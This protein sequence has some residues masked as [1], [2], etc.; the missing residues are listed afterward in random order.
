MLFP[1]RTAINLIMCALITYNQHHILLYKKVPYLN[2]LKTVPVHQL[3]INK[4][5]INK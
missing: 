1:E 2:T 5:K 3:L 4:V